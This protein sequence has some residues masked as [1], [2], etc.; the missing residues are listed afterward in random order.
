MSQNELNQ[1]IEACQV[2]GKAIG[3]IVVL[4]LRVGMSYVEGRHPAI[5]PVALQPAVLTKESA[6][7]YLG[8]KRTKFDE[9]RKREDL[10]EFIDA[11]RPKFPRD[12]LDAYIQRQRK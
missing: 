4:L 11:G 12:K 5:V 1:I 2:L 8:I 3:H 10:G 7:D 6:C 9:L